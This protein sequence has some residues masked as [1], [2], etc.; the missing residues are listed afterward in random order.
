MRKIPYHTKDLNEAAYLFSL[1]YIPDDILSFK[2][3]VRKYADR[4]KIIQPYNN[5]IFNHAPIRY[6]RAWCNGNLKLK[7]HKFMNARRELKK[8][9][10]AIQKGNHVN[11]HLD[12]Y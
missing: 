8:K 1:G 9:I 12:H 4:P 10:Y 2:R 5:F 11:N 6:Q 3:E 7:V